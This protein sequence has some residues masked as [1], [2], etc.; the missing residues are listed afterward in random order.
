MYTT[1][2]WKSENSSFRL[3]TFY[4]T[5]RWNQFFTYSDH[6]NPLA[7]QIYHIVVKIQCCP[8]SDHK[9]C[10]VQLK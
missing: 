7:Q 10:M 2:K 4:G 3:Q 6:K 1:I 5:P 9:I 8:L